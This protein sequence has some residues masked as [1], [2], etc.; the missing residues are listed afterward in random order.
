MSISNKQ[1]APFVLIF[2]LL[3]LLFIYNFSYY[4]PFT[5]NAFVVSNV[6]PVAANVN[7]YI[8]K[9]YVHNGQYVKRGQ[10]LFT[11]FKKPYIYQYEK[12]KSNLEQAQAQLTVLQAQVEKTEHLL[13]SKQD[14]YNQLHFDYQH[15]QM[16]LNDRAVSKV[17]VNTILQEQNAAQNEV[18]AFKKEL[19]LTKAQLTVQTMKI[20][21]LTAIM[22]NAKVDLAETTV[23]AKNNGI[24]QNLFSSLGTPIKI[25]EP[26]FSFIDTDHLFIQANFSEIDLR[27]VKPGDRVSIYPRIYMGAKSY[28]GV[29]ES[30][31]WASSRQIT[32]HRS[33]QQIVTN[34]EN[35]WLL[36]PQRFPV[37]IRLLDY[38]AKHYPLPVGAS[39]YVYVHT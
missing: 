38:D 16:A 4:F 28:Q 27:R 25:R 29:V 15:Y 36:L 37:Q 9:I 7:G 39:A 21:S 33:Q 19:E 20:K 3:I 31:H 26:I 30:I 5:N 6:R 14:R 1:R 12:T 2:C 34:N 13:K 22:N 32:D 35:N 18:L 11:V 17:K 23:Y 8:T 10:P 24:V